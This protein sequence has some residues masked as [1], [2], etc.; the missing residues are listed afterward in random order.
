MEIE[1][2]FHKTL[3]T[4]FKFSICMFYTKQ[5]ELLPEEI[6]PQSDKEIAFF[7]VKG[8]DIPNYPSVTFKLNGKFEKDRKGKMVFVSSGA[9]F[10]AKPD[11]KKAMQNFLSSSM[12]TGIGK[13]TAERLVRAF[14]MDVL[15][16]I[17]KEPERLMDVKGMTKKRAE[18]IKQGFS[19]AVRYQKVAMY[20]G[21]LEVPM[22]FVKRVVDTIDKNPDEIVE[23]LKYNPYCLIDRHVAGFDMCDKIFVLQGTAKMNAPVRVRACIKVMTKQLC[24]LQGGTYAL[25]TE[26]K[27][28]CIK[29][30]NEL[31]TKADERVTP[32]LYDQEFK[33]LRE[34]HEL[35]IRSNHYVYPYIFDAT[36]RNIALGLLRLND[37]ALH[38]DAA[39]IDSYIDDYM[40]EQGI[41]LAPGQRAACKNALTKKV[42]VITGGPG[43][44][45]TTII[46]CI[47]SVYKRYY[48]GNVVCMAPTGKAAR[49]MSEATGEYASTVHSRLHI[50]DEY[51]T[52]PPEPID[53]GLVIIDET[54]MV[55]N[56]LMSK[57][58]DAL[59][60]D[61]M[62]ILAGDIDQLPSVGV[63]Q[64][65]NDIINSH[66]V[67]TS[68]LTETFR[69]KGGSAI[70]DNAQKIN[71]GKTDLIYNDDFIFVPVK[72]EEQA[73][74]TIMEIYNK[75]VKQWG[76]EQVALL[77]PLRKTQAGK[78]ICASDGLN[79]LLKE[80]SNP[81]GKD[82]D[83]VRY[84]S[85]LFTV[86]DRVMQWKNKELSSNGDIGEIVKI[87]H[88]E[89]DGDSCV[90]E[91]DNGNTETVSIRDF[92]TIDY[93]YAMSIHKS[94][95]SEYNS[96]IIPM[97]SA[98]YCQLFKRNLL[99]TG[100]TRAKKKVIIVGDV[101]CIN[102]CIHAKD[103][104]QRKTL[105]TARLQY[106][107]SKKAEK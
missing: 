89:D 103:T 29:K 61:C 19:R 27:Q 10:V 16:V 68:R 42:S 73:K 69:Q 99:Y 64:V 34:T 15:T 65:L 74:D 5:I 79:P 67:N 20:L 96:V 76:I 11:S 92:D 100:V 28:L 49:R 9:Y 90:I 84:E 83:F 54:S 31:V 41:K 106:N 53:D 23:M 71:S 82:E 88:D 107:A 98:Q 50:L 13:T 33:T 26:L 24:A 4:N 62:L 1:C 36:E 91:W 21:K 25:D 55:D 14:G 86:G 104:S 18:A 87:I 57:I 58:V 2:K 37:G 46:K 59:A 35:V 40:N 77:C 93:A 97:L 48:Q 102:R 7:T 39:I 45:K 30:L 70:I 56:A 101:N 6:R 105:L 12:F 17:Q 94:Q 43:T 72:D 85:K 80:Q 32:E 47:I 95:G 63:G 22:A 8:E 81:V 51:S 3:W 38:V 78:H 66:E 75:E 60:T 44:G 52:T